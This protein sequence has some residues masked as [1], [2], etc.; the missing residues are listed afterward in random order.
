MEH[1]EELVTSCR[2]ADQKRLRGTAF[3]HE[4]AKQDA[5]DARVIVDPEHRSKDF[6]AT[7]PDQIERHRSV[8]RRP[9]HTVE[10]TIVRPDAVQKDDE[11]IGV[12]LIVE[13]C[14]RIADQPRIALR[15]LPHVRRRQEKSPFDRGVQRA[16]R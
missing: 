6:R 13:V 12:S 16:R 14:H 3:V 8:A 5:Q 9:Y 7:E 10:A 15:E 2:V 1:A 11:P 4:L